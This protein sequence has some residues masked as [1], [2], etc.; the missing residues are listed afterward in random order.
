MDEVWLCE[1]SR[2]VRVV[3]SGKVSGN[4]VC[5]AHGTDL[6]PSSHTHF[7]RICSD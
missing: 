7:V 6:L 2:V 4:A 5:R 1:S 3:L